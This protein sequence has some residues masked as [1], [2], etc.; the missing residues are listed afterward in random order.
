MSFFNINSKELTSAQGWFAN[1]RKDQV[2]F[3][4][5]LAINNTAKKVK[6]N[7]EKNVTHAFDSPTRTTKN[8]FYME[9][10]TPKSLRAKVAVKNK[11][12][13]GKPGTPPSYYLEPHIAGGNRYRKGSERQ[14][15]TTGILP[16]NQWTVQ[17]KDAR[18][19][20]SG[21][22]T[23]AQYIKILSAVRGFGE[24]GYIAN[25]PTSVKSTPYFVIPGVGIFKRT[26]KR[27]IKSQLIF[28]SKKPNYKKRFD[29]HG[30]AIKTYDR[31]F[32]NEFDKALDYAIRTAK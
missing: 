12:K 30:V 31:H 32:G 17:G 14:L 7:L 2:P 26:G 6:S 27:T 19:N 29:F 24:K 9:V 4:T 5:S 18:L 25:R 16:S 15:R 8:A 20:K 28:V 1:L 22:I 13:T 10:S 23:H 11:Y 3:A 21:N